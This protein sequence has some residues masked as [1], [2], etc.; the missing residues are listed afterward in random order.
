MTNLLIGGAYQGK[1]ALAVRLFAVTCW[2]D[3]ADCTLD[4][5]KQADGVDRLHLLVRRRLEAGQGTDGLLEA[6]VGKTVVCDEIGCGIVPLD[7]IDRAWREAVGRL[8]CDLAARADRVIRVT[9]G[10]PQAIKGDV[11]WN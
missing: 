11:V 6:L 5:L 10:L 3:G 7:P 4:A 1:H 8:L 9:G 2:A